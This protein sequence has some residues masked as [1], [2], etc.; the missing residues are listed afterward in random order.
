MTRIHKL[1]LM[2]LVLGTMLT[3]AT[4]AWAEGETTTESQTQ[5]DMNTDTGTGTTIYM[6]PMDANREDN[7]TVFDVKAEKTVSFNDRVK[8]RLF[9]DLFNI[10][11]SHASETISRATGTSYLKPSAILAP[12]TARV[13]FRFIF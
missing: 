6:E 3:A 4:V 11:N 1:P 13:G 10:T 9:L 8:A 7:I 12:F 2:A 5:T